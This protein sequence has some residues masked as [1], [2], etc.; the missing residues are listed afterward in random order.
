MVA[1]CDV[2]VDCG[3]TDLGFSGLPY[4]YDNGRDGDDNV[5]VRLDRAVA[6]S[7]WRDLFG[8]TVLH[9]LVSSRSDHCHY[10]WR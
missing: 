1:F 6:C 2:L 9:H 8:E 5:K 3:L 4:T 7:E 10:F